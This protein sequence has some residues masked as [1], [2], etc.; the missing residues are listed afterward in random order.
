[1]KRLLILMLVFCIGFTGCSSAGVSQ[2]EYDKVVKERDKYKSDYEYIL[3]EYAEYQAKEKINEIQSDVDSKIEE[4]KEEG[5]G[6]EKSGVEILGEYT[7]PDGIGWFTRHF[8]IIKNNTNE[9]VDVSTSS[10]AYDKKENLLGAE[11]AEFNALGAG[12]TSVLYEAFE[13]EGKID[14]YETEMNFSKSKYYESVIQDLSYEKKDIDKGAVFKVTNNGQD[15]AEF[16]E[17][18]ALFFLDGKLVDFES[19]YFTDD[20]SEIK[21]GKTISKQMT[22]YE[23]FDKIEFYLTG[24]K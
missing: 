3:N 1:M 10:L 8:V 21:P 15:A 12:C 9:T 7:L 19:T 4:S 18:Y 24:R 20:D 13:V 11:D 14:H 22:S 23:K 2:E 16:V 5:E 17:G 6:K